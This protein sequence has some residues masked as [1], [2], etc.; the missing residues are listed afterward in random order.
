LTRDFGSDI[1]DAI[2]SELVEQKSKEVPSSVTQDSGPMEDTAV[3]ELHKLT[4]YFGGL[5]AVNELDLQVKRGEILGL[6][7]PN[8]AGKTTVFNMISGAF[9]PTSGQ[10]MFQGKNI[11]GLKP[12]VITEAGIARTFQLTTVFRD[13]TV[14]ENVLVGRHLYTKIG[15][16]SA[17]FR[18]P[19]TRS[20]ERKALE[21]ASEILEFMGLAPLQYELAKNLPHGH[22]RALGIAVSLAAEP[23]LLLLD[24]PMTGMNPEETRMMMGIIDKIRGTGIHVLLVEHDMKAVMGLCDRIVVL[25]Y[26]SKIAEGLPE[27][28]KKNKDV[29]EAY[30]GSE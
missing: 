25:N 19:V 28:I 20:E 3:L 16:W 7:G 15:F 5:A 8:G 10:I 26:G 6:I 24:E 17:L 12:H 30:L 14:L 13:L 22:L 18:A 11:S 21:K 29:I 2:I 9:S 4:K 23:E 1:R 27:E